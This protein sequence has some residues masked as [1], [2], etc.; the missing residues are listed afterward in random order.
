MS[1]PDREEMQRQTDALVEAIKPLLANH[2]PAV[3]G[4]AL[5]E[6]TALWIAGHRPGAR[7]QMLDLQWDM[8]RKLYPIAARHFWNGERPAART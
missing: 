7:R 2:H 5:A 1:E 4:A 3:M 6:L 8:V